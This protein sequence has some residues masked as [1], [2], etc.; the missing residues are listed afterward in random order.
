[1]FITFRD[2]I[3]ADLVSIGLSRKVWIPRVLIATCLFILLF[4]TN[5]QNPEK[6]KY[7]KYSRIWTLIMTGQ[8]RIN[9]GA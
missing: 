4:M 8:M 5:Q 9:C 1:M 3:H 7:S 2:I 6:L